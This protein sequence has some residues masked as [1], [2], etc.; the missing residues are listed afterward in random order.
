M[1]DT[2]GWLTPQDLAR[3]TGF[4]VSFIRSQ[5]KDGT[6]EATLVQAPARQRGRWRIA[7][8]EALRYCERLGF[9]RS[10]IDVL[11]LG[12]AAL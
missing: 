2:H 12:A 7:L 1:P 8:D 3:M 5:I 4:S 11:A 6:L 9:N 10:T